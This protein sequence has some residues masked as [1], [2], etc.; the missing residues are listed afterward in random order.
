MRSGLTC[1]LS[2]SL[3]SQTRTET[4]WIQGG[5][6]VGDDLELLALAVLGLRNSLFETRDALAVEFLSRSDVQVELAAV[7]TH[8]GAELLADVLE[9]A[10]AVV[11]GQGGEEVLEGVALVAT[12]R[13]LLQLG[14][15]FL[16]VGACQ[17]RCPD[18]R[19]QLAVRLERLAEDSQGTGNLVQRRGLDRCR[20][21][22]LFVSISLPLL[23]RFF[24]LVVN[25]TRIFFLFSRFLA[26]SDKRIER[27]QAS[28]PN[29]RHL[30]PHHIQPTREREPE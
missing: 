25:S 13:E 30:F 19:C 4:T 26:T 5:T 23:L 29:R 22:F 15:D 10:Q 17:G 1:I 27:G 12:A 14:D 6:H 21:L 3:L 11:L 20:V 9:D 8:Q 18:D 2:I 16:L 28:L 24:F 7:S